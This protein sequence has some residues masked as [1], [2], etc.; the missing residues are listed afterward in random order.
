[1]KEEAND[2]TNHMALISPRKCNR[3]NSYCLYAIRN[4]MSVRV[5]G[6]YRNS[7]V[8]LNFCKWLIPFYLSIT[9]KAF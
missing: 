9:S 2:N 1:M 8:D 4:L 3:K 7:T 6:P 5:A